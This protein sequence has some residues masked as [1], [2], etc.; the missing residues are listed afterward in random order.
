MGEERP[1]RSKTFLA[2]AAVHTSMDNDKHNAP[3]ALKQECSPM[4]TRYQRNKSGRRRSYQGKFLPAR[5]PAAIRS[6]GP[7]SPAPLEL[8]ET[9]STRQY[10]HLSG[11]SK[12]GK[13]RSNAAGKSR[14]TADSRPVR[15]V[16]ILRERLASFRTG[17]GN[18]IPWM[19]AF[20]RPADFFIKTEVQQMHMPSG[21]KVRGGKF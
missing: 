13:L 4:P 8:P 19:I 21:P 5:F 10:A 11:G 14:P 12:R 6:S 20:P 17:R 18:A 16:P 2:L 9:R 7:I 3:V 15:V 1:E